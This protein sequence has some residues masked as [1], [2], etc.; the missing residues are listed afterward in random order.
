MLFLTGVGFFRLQMYVELEPHLL[1][2]QV[3]IALFCG[4][5][6]WEMS[7]LSALLIQ[8]R[9]PGLERIRLRIFLLLASL[10]IISNIGFLLRWQLHNW[11]DGR[12]M[13]WPEL[14]DYS[15]VTGVVIFYTTVTLGVYEGAYLWKQWKKVFTE[16][17]RLIQ[18]EW[19]AKYDLL[20]S[21]INPHFLFNSLNSLSSLISEN[22][23]KA[24]EFTDEM[25]KVY[26]YLLRSNDQELVTLSS[27]IQFIRSY[28]HL[29]KTRHGEGFR[30]NL[31]IHA[32]A[33]GYQLPSLTLQLLVENAVKHNVVDKEHP[34]TVTIK[35]TTINRLIVEN[36]K[37]KKSIT[38]PSTGVGLAN[39]KAKFQLL[40]EQGISIEETESCFRVI[41][42]L[43]K[44]EE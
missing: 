31:E 18:Q 37:Q 26:R 10:I 22:P 35:T 17:E 4:Y 29:L 6:G 13:Q 24:E 25:S 34:L 2:N 39:I 41:I 40:D 16:K 32:A 38:I 3:G 8:R 28:S 7:R 21:Q 43:I 27:E 42:P 30:L 44:G 33:L 14:M 20:K 9:L 5:M 1:V 12:P 11:I 19:Q 15:A 23:Q 36:N